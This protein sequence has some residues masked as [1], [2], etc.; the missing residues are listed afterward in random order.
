MNSHNYTLQLNRLNVTNSDHVVG[1]GLAVFNAASML[2]SKDCIDMK[3]QDRRGFSKFFIE[4][5][6][7]ACD[8][9]DVQKEDAAIL[10]LVNPEYLYYE[11]KGSAPLENTDSIRRLYYL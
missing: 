1:S 5:V 11:R 6:Y 4:S 10:P 2:Q 7:R 9:L 8:Y 3:S